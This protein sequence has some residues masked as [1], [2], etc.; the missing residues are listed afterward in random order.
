MKKMKRLL[1]VAMLFALMLVPQNASAA[2]QK[3][4]AM[5]A[6]KSYMAQ[7]GSSARFAVAYLDKDS[8]PE[9]IY[10]VPSK[11]LYKVFTWKS[12]KMKTVFSADYSK[13]ISNLYDFKYYYKKK[14]V[15][16]ATPY[17][18]AAGIS[19]KTYFAYSGGKYK[20]VLDRQNAFGKVSCYKISGTKFTKISSAQFNSS[21]KKLV[22]N[23]KAAK[24]TY[25]KN[26]AA[27]R[28]KRLK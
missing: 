17:T 19:G 16:L 11:P 23:T 27:N 24:L 13:D 25:Y 1:L 15:L 28:T 9:L 4:K 8:V 5:K 2:S 14:G 7:K 20:R 12:G 26:T 18:G 22:G 21:L 10:Y 3:T 6:Y